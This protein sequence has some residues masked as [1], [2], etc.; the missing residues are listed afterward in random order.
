MS[1]AIVP[2]VP[3]SPARPRTLRLAANLLAFQVAW[4]AC[5][6][7]AARGEPL[8]GVAAAAL[9]IALHGALSGERAKEALLIGA[10]L[11]IGLA[12]DT[13]M[14]RAGFV[15]YASPGP[16]PQLAPAWILAL[17][18]LFATTLRDPLRWLHG[19]PVLAALL[20]GVGGA[21][22]YAS[23]ARLGACEFPDAGRALAVLA[24]GWGVIAPVLVE[25]ARRLDAPR[26]LAGVAP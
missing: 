13:A 24:V 1:F 10:A 19:R 11:A 12:W 21:L 20:G 4:F 6:I 14:L 5:V 16:L 2:R 9:A 26:P 8:A 3:S 22:S 7:G 15:V 25:A 18:A 23:A 17:W